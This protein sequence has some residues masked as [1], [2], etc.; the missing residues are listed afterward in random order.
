[1]TQENLIQEI[2]ELKE[3][4]G[5]LFLA[6]YY[7][8]KEIQELADYCGDSL[9]LAQM[10]QNS[11]AQTVLLAG[12]VFMA[13]SVKILSP[14]KRVLVPDFNAGCSLVSGTPYDDFVKWR[15]KHPEHIAIT[16]INSSAEVKSVSDVICTSSNAEKIVAA[17]PEDR[18][19]LFGP[20]KNLGRFLERKTKREMLQW[21]G[22]CEVHDLFSA[23][24]LFQMKEENPGALVLAHPECEDAVLAYS[25]FIGST[26]AIL[27]EV[28]TN[29]TTDTFIVATE[30][31]IF[32]QL[33]K[34]RPEAKLIQAPFEGH[35]QCND[36]PYMKL[37]NL[38]KIHKCL[39]NLENEVSVDDN[40]I[41][42][43]RI[44]LQRMMDITQGDSVTWPSQ[45]E[46]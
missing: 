42:R 32:H 28:K 16:Y 8:D 9:F 22:Q 33:Q 35:C 11:E 39:M 3:K 12:V 13:E 2:K 10:G 38:E 46:V 41:E 34:A 19:I 44:P 4:H 5:V 23:K 45:F 6:H 27:N 29:K 18:P 17:I 15:Q 26:S 30:T 36:C 24:K 43:A 31:G 21:P 40:L 25:D 7:Q 1:M 14:T 37:N 20:D